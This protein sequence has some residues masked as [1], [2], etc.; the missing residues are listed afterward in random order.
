[1]H[2]G[3]GVKMICLCIA[4]HCPKKR[5]AEL[6]KEGKAVREEVLMASIKSKAISTSPLWLL[7]VQGDPVSSRNINGLK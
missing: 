3:M 6:P 7:L 4:Y 2:Y 1:M 5:E